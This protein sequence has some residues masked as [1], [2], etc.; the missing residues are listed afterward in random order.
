MSK[1]IKELGLEKE[2]NQWKENSKKNS[3]GINSLV[4]LNQPILMLDLEK[5]EI[6]SVVDIRQPCKS[7]DFKRIYR[8]KFSKKPEY[9][10]REKYVTIL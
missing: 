2:Y 4:K 8:I 3:I 7:T 1:I 9:W 6:G 10:L 5:D